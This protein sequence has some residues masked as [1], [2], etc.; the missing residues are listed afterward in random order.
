MHRAGLGT[1]SRQSMT[2][3]G[4][5]SLV[6]LAKGRLVAVARVEF[7]WSVALAVEMVREGPAVGRVLV[8]DSE[9]VVER[10]ASVVGAMV[11]GCAARILPKLERHPRRMRLKIDGYGDLL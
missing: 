4:A 5:S 2:G 6:L 11:S 3:S 7:V 1:G 10:W 9:A 8:G